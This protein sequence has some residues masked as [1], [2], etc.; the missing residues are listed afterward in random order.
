MQDRILLANEPG[1]DIE[2]RRRKLH[3]LSRF[4][5][6]LA[7]A[8]I[9][10]VVI[11]CGYLLFDHDALLSY[12][13]RNVS[14]TIVVPSNDRLWLAYGLSLIPAGVFVVTMWETRRFF[15]LLGNSRLFDRGAPR[16]LVRLGYLAITIATVEIIVHTLVVLVM[17]SANPPGHRLLVIGISST[18]LASLIVGLLFL[19]FAL[20][21][22]ETLRLEDEN[23]SFV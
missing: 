4:A 13:R 10:L 15:V 8:G 2:A 14:E 7:L 18:D 12:L 6:Q 17:T 20:V 11:Y 16:V 19:A 1:A 9:A 23:R 22:Q 5:E 21:M 3:R